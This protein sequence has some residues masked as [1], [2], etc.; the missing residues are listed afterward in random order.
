MNVVLLKANNGAIV[1]VMAIP[2]IKYG[3]FQLCMSTYNEADLPK[4]KEAVYDFQRYI[5]E[6]Y[7]K[8]GK[9]GKKLYLPN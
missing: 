6:C 3:P 8:Q 7:R 1:H 5:A 4:M 9:P 2:G